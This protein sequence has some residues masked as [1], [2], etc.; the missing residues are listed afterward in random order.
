[1]TST[2][3]T[4]QP[5]LETTPNDPAH[6]NGGFQKYIIPDGQWHLYEWNLDETAVGATNGWGDVPSIVSGSPT[7]ADGPHT[8]DSIIFRFTT[9]ANNLLPVTATFFMDFFAKSDS[10]SISN[11]L[12]TPCLAT[13]GVIPIGPVSADTNVVTVSG[14]SSNANTITV[15]QD[16]GSGMVAIGTKTT[17]IT[18]GNN[19]V[20]VSGSLKT[21]KLGPPKK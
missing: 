10:G 7:L 16:S 15:Y 8:L 1:M 2:N 19:I 17:G 5:W 18:A 6:N 20:T 14:V 12:A 9:N 21:R 4:V 3:W 13:T 11:V